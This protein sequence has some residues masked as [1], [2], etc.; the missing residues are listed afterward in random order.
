MTQ[1]TKTVL[2]K[3]T[4][5]KTQQAPNSKRA[6]DPTPF[7]GTT[8]YTV[9]ASVTVE[10]LYE[11]YGNKELYN[12]PDI[13]RRV[14]WINLTSSKFLSDLSFGRVGSAVAV[15]ELTSAVK[16]SEM[17]NDKVGAEKLKR[18][19]DQGYTDSC[20][21]G[22]N[23]LENLILFLSGQLSFSGDM[24]GDDKRVYSYKDARFDDLDP[25]VQRQ[26]MKSTLVL[27]KY[28]NVPHAEHWEVFIALNSGMPLNAQERRNALPSF[29]AGE[30]RYQAE[31]REELWNR[32]NGVSKKVSRMYDVESLASLLLHFHPTLETSSR[33][34]TQECLN[35]FYRRGVNKTGAVPAEYSSGILSRFYEIVDMASE[36]LKNQTVHTK[37]TLIPYKSYWATMFAAGWMFDNGLKCGGNFTDLY[38]VIRET[39]A[40]L[41][42]DSRQKQNAD[43]ENYKKLHPSET[44]SEVDEKFP[45][46]NYYWKWIPRNQQSTLRDQRQR[47]FLAQFIPAAT[48]L[49]ESSVKANDALDAYAFPED[50]TD[51]DA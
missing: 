22:Q 48:S 34:Y 7:K 4:L 40:K 12:D 19:I 51:D 33:S 29:I 37:S 15:A 46:T 30:L 11:H 47:D 39:D 9:P 42:S 41:E 31:Q 6:G 35:H 16:A 10:Y 20:L 3:K 32:I 44:Q 8:Y 26:L 24:L 14:V 50:E 2:R 27:V 43:K 1:K 36:I 13:Q 28:Q 21:D 49:L 38:T 45:D 25:E 23:R 5:V 18:I 17:L